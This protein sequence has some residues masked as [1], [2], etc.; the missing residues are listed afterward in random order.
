MSNLKF[1]TVF[2]NNKNYLPL[3]PPPIFSIFIFY[4][5]FKKYRLGQLGPKQ[6]R[7]IITMN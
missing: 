4:F 3:N 6:I 1:T 5:I 2:A 7:Y